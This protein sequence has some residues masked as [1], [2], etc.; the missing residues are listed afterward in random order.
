[1]PEP[2]DRRHDQGWPRAGD[3]RHPRRARGARGEGGGRSRAGGRRRLLPGRRL[4]ADR[5][6]APGLSGG[7]RQLRGRPAERSRARRR[8]P[9]GRRATA[10]RTAWSAAA[11]PSAWSATWA[12]SACP[13]R[14]RPT[15]SAGH[16]FFSKVDGWQGWLARIPT[17]MAVGYQGGG[18]RGRLAADPRLL[19]GARAVTAGVRRARWR[20]LA[21]PPCSECSPSARWRGLVGVL[22]IGHPRAGS[23]GPDGRER[24]GRGPRRGARGGR[25]SRPGARG[26]ARGG[27]AAGTLGLI[28]PLAVEPA[29]GWRRRAAV[30]SEGRR[31]GAG[32]GGASRLL[33]RLHADHPLRRQAGLRARLPRSRHPAE[34][35]QRRGPA[36][37]ADRYLCRCRG[38][39]NQYDPQIEMS[40]DGSLYAAWLD[41]FTPASRSR[42]PT[43]AGESWTKPMH[44]D[45]R[46][47]WSDKPIVAV[48]EDGE[49]RLHRLQRPHARGRLGG[50]LARPRRHFGQPVAGRRGT[51]ATT[52]RAAVSSPRTARSP[53]GRPSYNQELERERCA[54]WRRP[55]PTA[56][57][58][59]RNVEVDRVAKQPDCVS[60]GCPKDFYGPQAAMAGDSDGRLLI[61]YNGASRRNGRQ[62]VYARHSGTAGRTWSART[63]LSPM[64]ANAAFPAAVGG[65]AGRLPGLVHGRPQGLGRPVERVVPRE[66]GRRQALVEGRCGSPTPPVAPPTFGPAASWSRTATTASSRSSRTAPPSPS[67][68]RESAT[69]APAAPGTTAR[70]DRRRIH[71]TPP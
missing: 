30:A 1:M 3:R 68:A 19:R 61:L 27:A 39:K 17:G 5:R 41:G 37:G 40:A 66:H 54:C 62:R 42:A 52:S 35:L 44:V 57:I 43:T 22:S 15:R 13:T 38:S 36:L 25:P 58:S 16:S 63:R 55:R 9:G 32:G 8:L 51:A 29:P 7:G 21:A 53:S 48:S 20:N 23:A 67:G 46:L 60:K 70:D 24:V 45:K 56:A 31:L 28:E 18:R 14:S 10:P 59:W 2:R 49:G 12:R 11:W 26:G 47:A 65:D 4:R 33:A 69:R 6:D 71:E 50:R 34:E 64:H